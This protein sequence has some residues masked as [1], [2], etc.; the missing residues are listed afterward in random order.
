MRHKQRYGLVKNVNILNNISGLILD[1]LMDSVIF[2]VSLYKLYSDYS[3]YCV[4]VRRSSDDT[5]KNIGFV[6]NYI[7]YEDLLDFCGASNGFVRTWYNQAGTNNFSN[8]NDTSQPKIVSEGVF[9]S[10]I[11]LTDKFF[12]IATPAAMSAITNKFTMYAKIKPLGGVNGWLFAVNN[13]SAANVSIGCLVEVAQGKIY[14][15]GGSRVAC[16]GTYNSWIKC[17]N[18]WDGTSVKL[19]ICDTTNSSNYSTSVSSHGVWS[20][21]SGRSA[22]VATGI[23]GTVFPGEI[24]TFILFSTNLSDGQISKFNV[25]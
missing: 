7:D 22:N 23:A 18:V 24:K 16:A 14:I 17:I 2:A 8:T 9:N 25:A 13:D 12:H 11:I 15:N 21:L 4:E 20:V 6:N 19:T 5:T 3:G 10:S 1:D